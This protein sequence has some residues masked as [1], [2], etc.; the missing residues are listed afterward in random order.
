VRFFKKKLLCGIGVGVSL[1][2]AGCAPL[3]CLFF[4]HPPVCDFTFY[5]QNP[6]VGEIITFTSLATD[7]DNNIDLFFWDYG[8]GI[9]DSG[10]QVR[11]IYGYPG[12]FKVVHQVKDKCGLISEKSLYLTVRPAELLINIEGETIVGETLKFTLSFSGEAL[13]YEWDFGDGEQGYGNP[14]YHSYRCWG[15]YTVTVKVTTPG[16]RISTSRDVDISGIGLPPIAH[17]NWEIDEYHILRATAS[18]RD[19]DILCLGGPPWTCCIVEYSW[20]LFLYDELLITT[21]GQTF[22]YFLA[23]EGL[24]TLILTVWDDEWQEGYDWIEFE[25]PGPIY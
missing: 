23:G 21:F 16:G 6:L 13:S 3:W 9:V 24:Y 14:V 19:N 1:F 10:K 7:P 17:I 8:D 4:N 15:L 5:P 11:H 2:L 12:T 18:A 25:W 22:E 20:H